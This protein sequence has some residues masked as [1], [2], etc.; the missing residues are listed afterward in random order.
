MLAAARAALPEL[1]ADARA[2]L[3]ARA[4]AERRRARGCSRS[5][6]SS[7]DYFER[8]LGGRRR[9]RDPVDARQLDPAAGRA[10]RLDTDPAESNVAPESLAALAAMVGAKEVSRDAARDVLTRLVEEGGDPR[11]IVEREGL[12]ALS[13]DDDGLADDRRPRDRR[14][15]RTPPS[16]SGRAT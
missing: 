10:D 8:A 7:A 9:E 15:T 11:A 1:P 5:G 14:P 2:A 13:G 3:R 6:P 16:R 4:R 12:G